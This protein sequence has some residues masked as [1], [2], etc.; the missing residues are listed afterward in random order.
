[1]KLKGEFLPLYQVKKPSR[2]GVQFLKFGVPITLLVLVFLILYWPSIEAYFNPTNKEEK[3]ETITQPV[4][5]AQ[6]VTNQA[7]NLHFDGVDSHNQPYTLIANEGFEFEDTHSELK[8]PKLTLKLNSGEIV[9]LSAE[10]AKYE[11]SKQKVEL[12]GNVV[13]T[14]STGYNFRTDHAWI[15]LTDSSALG[16]D[17]VT[18]S[19]PNGEI[20]SQAGFQLTEKGDK[21]KFMGRPELHILK[22][23]K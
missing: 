4:P 11:R 9:T 1:M 23:G 14:H 22:R 3:I 10:N 20:Y 16:H 12:I 18:G 2:L 21:I 13:V 19:G 5:Q 17:P 7:K 15:D 8:N 6:G